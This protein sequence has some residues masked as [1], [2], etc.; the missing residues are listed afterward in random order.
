MMDNKND[1]HHRL[2]EDDEYKD[3]NDIDRVDE[4]L[5]VEEQT[6]EEVAQVA[7][8]A[9][10]SASQEESSH[11]QLYMETEKVGFW[12]RFW[13]Y[14][15]DVIVISS[16]NAIALSPFAFFREASVF[17][18]EYMSVI[19][20]LS[21]IVY[22]MYFLFMTK[23]FSQ[24]LGKM[25]LGIKVIST[26]QENVSWSDLFFREIIGRLIHNIFFILKLLYLFVAFTDEKKGLH[27]IIGNTRVVYAKS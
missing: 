8:S 11:N 2:P 12:M 27:D 4:Q 17:Q 21:A 1:T 24:T 5:I 9:T 22:Y 14:M 18:F 16:I 6:N 19:G 25:I 20:I 23:I 26:E 13:A 7:S 10:N 3:E 15:I